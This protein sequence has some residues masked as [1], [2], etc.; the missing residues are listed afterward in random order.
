MDG[1]LFPPQSKVIVTSF[2]KL[3]SISP[4]CEFITHNLGFLFQLCDFYHTIATLFLTLVFLFLILNL[5]FDL[6]WKEDFIKMPAILEVY[7][8]L[9]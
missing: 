3:N 5:F 6:R 9:S 7:F 2:C 8:V 4:S 1:S